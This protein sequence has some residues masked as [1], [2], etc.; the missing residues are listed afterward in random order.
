MPS[1]AMTKNLQSESMV[2]SK[3]SGSQVTPTIEAIPSPKDLDIANPGI[4]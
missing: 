4:F 2:N 3:I 1:V